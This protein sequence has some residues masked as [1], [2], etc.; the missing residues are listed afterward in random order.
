MCSIVEIKGFSLLDFWRQMLNVGK[1]N[2]TGLLMLTFFTA[3]KPLKNIYQAI[4]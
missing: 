3:S 1:C 2:T 4:S